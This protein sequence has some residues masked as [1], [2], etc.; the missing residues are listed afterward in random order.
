MTENTPMTGE[1]TVAQEALFYSVSLKRRVPAEQML[2]SIDRFVDLSG[3]RER[4]R[5]FYSEMGWPLIDPK[6]MILM[7]INGYCA[8]P[9]AGCAARC[10]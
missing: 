9:S 6:L 2:C 8:V 1:R 5:P 3:I 4:L 7:L 10:I